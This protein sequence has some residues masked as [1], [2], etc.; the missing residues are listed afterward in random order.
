MS[1][2]DVRMM[3]SEADDHRQLAELGALPP[4]SDDENNQ[5]THDVDVM[6]EAPEIDTT[7]IRGG[8]NCKDRCNQ[9]CL[10]L[11]CL[12]FNVCI[13]IAVLVTLIVY[14]ERET[15]LICQTITTI[16][17]AFNST[18]N[19]DDMGCYKVNSTFSWTPL[20]EYML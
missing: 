8:S 6:S 3:T 14:A 17:N 15:N 18:Y 19:V 9:K 20:A 5:Q 11:L 1:W 13:I 4:S 10:K 7:E 2:K 12:A 16:G